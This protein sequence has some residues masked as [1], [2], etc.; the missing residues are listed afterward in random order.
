MS[1]N[2]WKK[3]QFTICTYKLLWAHISLC[4]NSF[5][6]TSNFTVKVVER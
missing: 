2:C 5:Q 6:K 3:I 4:P 1:V